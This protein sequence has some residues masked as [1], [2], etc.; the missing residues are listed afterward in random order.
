MSVRVS[1]RV[2]VSG[3]MV[4]TY[5]FTV[6]GSPDCYEAVKCWHRL[7]GEY[8]W[9]IYAATPVFVGERFIRHERAATPVATVRELTDVPAKIVQ[10]QEAL[11]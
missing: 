11:R 5:R 8:R 1:R 9:H 10:L 2:K 6:D 3:A 4:P 7:L